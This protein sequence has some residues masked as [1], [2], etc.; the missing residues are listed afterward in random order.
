MKLRHLPATLLIFV[1]PLVAQSGAELYQRAVT[2]ERA[3]KM[4]EAIQLYEKVATDFA[5]D[6]P[7]AA[8]ALSQAAKGYE[9]LGQDGALRLYERIARDFPDQTEYATTARDKVKALREPPAPPTM[10]TRMIVLAESLRNLK[11]FL[12]TDGVRVLYWDDEGTTLWSADIANNNRRRVLQL[13][14]GEARPIVIPSR[15]LSVMLLRKP[16]PDTSYL[17]AIRADGTGLREFTDAASKIS[18]FGTVPR[19]TSALTWSWDNRFVIVTLGTRMWKLNVTDGQ[20]AE[21]PVG[22]Q[23]LPLVKGLASPDGRYVAF[24]SRAGDGGPTVYTV[25]MQGGEPLAVATGPI[26]AIDWT[27]DG[28]YLLIADATA[29]QVGADTTIQAMKDGRPIGERT[30]LGDQHPPLATSPWVVASGGILQITNTAIREFISTFVASLDNQDRLGPW[31]ALKLVDNPRQAVWSFDGKQIAYVSTEAVTASDKGVIRLHDLTT[32]DDRELFRPPGRANSCAWPARETYL[33][34]ASTDT[35]QTT[36]FKVPV[37]PGRAE[38][39]RVFPGIV[40]IE[41]FTRDRRLLIRSA[42]N[43]I[44]RWEVGGDEPVFGSQTISDLTPGGRD[45][46]EWVFR[47]SPGAAVGTGSIE[48]REANNESAAWRHL[49]DMPVMGPR[50]GEEGRSVFYTKPDPDGRRGLYRVATAGGEPQRLGDI[51]VP[52]NAQ[53]PVEVSPDGRH[54]LTSFQN[55]ENGQLDYFLLENFIPRTP[56][57][58]KPAAAR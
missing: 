34:C 42:D 27:R 54:F 29:N 57:P 17:A 13:K 32:G 12:I 24:T 28:G 50:V 35:L 15:D 14:P 36:F 52:S 39:V 23:L 9:K 33:Y 25:P 7:L 22:N 47:R 19:A 31:R 26:Q 56:A 10:A 44:A 38:A 6:R 46:D 51:A 45:G 1:V 16:V 3:G 58:A 4:S 30:R 43:R 53:Q 2:A 40:T 41:G 48:I 5:K 8:K 21:I 55:R 37:D 49:V 18:Q 20:A 11:N